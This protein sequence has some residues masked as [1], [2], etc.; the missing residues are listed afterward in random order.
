[1]RKIK[2]LRASDF[3]GVDPKKLDEWKQAVLDASKKQRVVWIVLG[4][5]NLILIFTGVGVFLGG[6][7]LLFIL[8]LIARTP[9]RLLKEA[10]LTH[11]DI[12]RACRS[13]GVVQTEELTKKCPQC[14]EVIK[15]E[16]LVCRFCGYTFKPEEAQEQIAKIRE[17]TQATRAA[18][19]M[20]DR[21]VKAG[22]HLSV[23]KILYYVSA[24]LSAFL[25]LGG[26]GMLMTGTNPDDRSGGIVILVIGLVF[27]PLCIITAWS[28]G[29]RKLWGRTLA[30]IIGICSL[31]NIPLGTILGVYTLVVM[32]SDEGKKAFARAG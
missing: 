28:I 21:Q 20:Q 32:F 14:A 27:T 15:A 4:L 10:G 23:L 16:A 17:E 6:F 8:F 25:V 12:R 9:N 3:P 5:L 18:L 2:D 7:L 22:G 31:L 19:E 1:M 13:I 29:K 30:I 26:I 24:G 11:A